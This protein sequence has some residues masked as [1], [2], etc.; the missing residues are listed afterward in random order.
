MRSPRGTAQEEESRD[1]EMELRHTQIFL[2]LEKRDSHQKRH[3]KS[4]GEL[5][6]TKTLRHHERQT[7]LWWQPRE[8]KKLM[9]HKRVGTILRPTEKCKRNGESQ[10]R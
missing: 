6:V 3:E 4:S 5:R 7:R 2:N 9:T 10:V 1:T 8:R